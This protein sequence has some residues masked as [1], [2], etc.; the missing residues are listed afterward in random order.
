MGLVPR[1][2]ALSRLAA[3]TGAVSQDAEILLPERPLDAKPRE[4]VA[5]SASTTDPMRVRGKRKWLPTRSAVRTLSETETENFEM[6]S[7][8]NSFSFFHF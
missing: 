8:Q 2:G 3:E 5:G 7:G 4:V 6:I 1:A